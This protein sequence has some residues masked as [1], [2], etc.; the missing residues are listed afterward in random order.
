MEKVVEVIYENGVFKPI[1][2]V[3][4]PEKTRGKVIVEEKLVGD[5]EEVSRK[6]DEVLKETRIDEDPLEV[7]LEMRKRPWD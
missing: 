2:K 7:L 1:K 5:I 3:A 4:L 6:I